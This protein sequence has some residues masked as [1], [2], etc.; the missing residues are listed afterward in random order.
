MCASPQ[1]GRLQEKIKKIHF[2]VCRG[3]LNKKWSP[4]L[5][6]LTATTLIDVGGL[7]RARRSSALFQEWEERKKQQEFKSLSGDKPTDCP[8]VIPSALDYNPLCICPIHVKLCWKELCCVVLCSDVEGRFTHHCCRAHDSSPYLVSWGMKPR[9]APLIQSEQT[10]SI[11]PSH[12]HAPA[13]AHTHLQRKIH[14]RIV[15]VY[16]RQRK[17]SSK[18]LP[19]F[20]WFQSH[21]HFVCPHLPTCITFS[22]PHTHRHTHTHKRTQ[23]LSSFHMRDPQKP[24]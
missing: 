15:V 6:T 24:A 11:V 4:F 18:H 13:R 17:L 20:H 9:Q 12:L 16:L 2:Y 22:L 23:L 5:K 1:S 19:N 10:L 7:S 3:K 8:Q 21:L 14:N